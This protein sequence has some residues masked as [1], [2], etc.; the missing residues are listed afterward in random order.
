M[1]FLTSSL[2]SPCQSKTIVLTGIFLAIISLIILETV[3][4]LPEP[5]EPVIKTCSNKLLHGIN[6]LVK[7]CDLIT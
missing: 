4:V 5:V 2:Y 3:Y 6:A 7:V 1:L